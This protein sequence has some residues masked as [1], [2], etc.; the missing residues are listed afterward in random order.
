MSELSEKIKE[1]ML[2]F[3]QEKIVETIRKCLSDGAN[4][5]DLI[6]AITVSF[7]EIGDMFEKGEIFIPHLMII[8]EAA[9][10]AIAEHIEPLLKGN[11]ERKTIGRVVIGTVAGDIHDIGKSIVAS[12]L[13]SAGF[14]VLDLGKDVPVEDFIKTVKEQNPDIVGMSAMITTTR[15]MQEKV[16]EALRSHGLREK[17]KVVVGGAPVSAEWAEKIGADGYAENAIE[18]VKL[19]KKLME[20]RS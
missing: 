17:V 11:A 10:N 1:A 14:E 12:M 15:P 2:T 19:A 18:A 6:N 5:L 3:D 8:S 16:I 13:F 4:P 7:E 20:G 9:K